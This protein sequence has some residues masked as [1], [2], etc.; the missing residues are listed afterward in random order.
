MPIPRGVARFNRR[1]LNHLMRPLARRAPGFAVVSHVGRS[2]GRT[3]RTPA[4]VF[5]RGDEHAFALTY[6]SDADWVRNVLA[7]GRCD[8]ETRGR[9][10]R[11]DAPRL[12]TDGQRTRAPRAARPI[13][14]ALNVDEFLV[15]RR[16]EH[17]AADRSGS[18][19]P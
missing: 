13:L 3:Y 12:V 14:R 9:H 5:R 4:N 7:A 17:D 2:S 6:G 15:M 11:L 16:S 1:V 19:L 18:D 8:I 10:V